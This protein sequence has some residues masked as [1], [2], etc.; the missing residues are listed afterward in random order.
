MGLYRK[1]LVV[2]EAVQWF[3]GMMFRGLCCGPC[4]LNDF[5]GE[6][7]PHVHT[8]HNHGNHTVYLEAGDWILPEPDGEHFYPCKPDIFAATYE[9][10]SPALKDDGTEEA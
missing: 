10:A 8:I 6:T 4:G 2:I 9:P 1:K 3:P 5:F 7:A